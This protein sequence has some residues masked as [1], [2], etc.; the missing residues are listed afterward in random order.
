MKQSIH[1]AILLIILMPF[2]LSIAQVFDISQLEELQGLQG[3]QGQKQE[4]SET[5]LSVVERA[6]QARSEQRK[7][8]ESLENEAEN[9]G[10]TGRSDFIVSPKSKTIQIPLKFFG[11]DYFID[12]P[13]TFA[14]VTDIPIPPDYT[15][16]PGDEIK[17]ILF[18]NKNKQYTLQVTR[19]GDIFLPEIGPISVAGLTF[20][21]LK[22]TMQQIV[23]NQIIG[24]KI[25][26]TLGALRSINIF[27]LGEAAQPGMYTVS[28]LSTLTNA[29]FTSGG[30]KTTG[31]LR[32][33]ELK[34]NGQLLSSFDFYNLLLDGDTSDDVRL[35]T[36][37]VIF[38]PPITKTIGI[39]GEVKRPGIYELKADET[40]EDLIN[41]AGTLKPKADLS[42]IEIQRV[43]SM[44]NGFNL[45]NFD[46]NQSSFSDLFLENGDI[47]TIQPVVDKMGKAILLSGHIQK[48]GFYPWREG[49][50]LLDVVS[51]TEDL[52]PMT[53][54]NYVLIKRENEFNQSYEILQFDLEE[55]FSI[56]ESK[57]NAVLKEKDEIVF[58]P[59]LLTAN[60]IN[61]KLIEDGYDNVD[62]MQRLIYIRK[63][64][65][66]TSRS[67]AL[68]AKRV[69]NNESSIPD[70]ASTSTLT[71][72]LRNM[73][74]SKFFQYTIHNYCELP[75]ELVKTIMD[76]A[77]DDTITKYCRR[78]LLDPIIALLKQQG[79]PEKNV[80]II[81]V[82]GNVEYTG[83][84]PLTRRATLE[85][86]L[87]ASGGLKEASYL[88]EI[89]ITR[90]ELNGKEF[91]LSSTSTSLK[92]DINPILLQSLDSITVKKLSSD[93]KTARIQG[94]VF[95]PGEYPIRPNETLQSLVHRAGGIK[96]TASINSAVFQRENLKQLE[97]DRL[98][99]L[100][101]EMRRNVVLSQQYPSAP[102]ESPVLNIGA[103]NTILETDLESMDDSQL[104]GRLVIDL[105]AIINN[106]DDGVIL[107][108]KDM[109]TI[110]KIRQ[111]ISVVGEV[112]VPNSH[113]FREDLRFKDYLD[114]SGGP[115]DYADV[116]S[117]Y[118]I[119]S[120]GSITRIA[121]TN[122][123]FFRT[124]S[125]SIT[126]G[127][128]IVLPIKIDQFS[129]LTATT[130]I[131][132][133]VYQMALAAA[134]V[135]SF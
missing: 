44:G 65:A 3:L 94:E 132:Q 129:A 88:E 118:I 81:T 49:M 104:L 100:Q 71:D 115:T 48:P 95:F 131:T 113:I 119:K 112:Y 105:E 109:L 125:S 21:D 75:Q 43:D 27:V 58:F 33:I 98:K 55:L 20:L 24:T 128:M 53:D 4:Q 9:F 10:Y 74:E 85:D 29:I 26:L 57:N 117:A 50:T 80:Q 79:T 35:M 126:P 8:K 1:T 83:Q 18:G 14:P 133:I 59:V 45:T 123:R 76:G 84:Y 47:L 64:F 102:G 116:N 62:E 2:S 111:V 92:G 12:A 72:D 70:S 16:G 42:S 31:S 61:V 135:N 78:Q 32:N 38:V 23:D 121:N 73:E 37:D 120:D 77:S 19:D 46:L 39:A 25:S 13:T 66:D 7:D 11:Y 124:N 130:E 63:S 60:L 17:I 41:F 68:L 91:R 5:P 107:E 122:S 69:R 93:I 96:D 36:G 56:S 86:A 54:M 52:L 110:P 101:K 87:K 99:Q 127:D 28:S 108:D 30:I 97:L 90:R 6:Q 67:E 89:E 82:Y 34:R 51:S 103:L 134:A 22:E 106:Q 15:L 40:A 114:L